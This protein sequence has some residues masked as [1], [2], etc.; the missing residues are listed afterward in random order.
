MRE[1]IVLVL[2]FCSFSLSWAQFL[3]TAS[4]TTKRGNAPSTMGKLNEEKKDSK[5]NIVNYV[6]ILSNDTSTLNRDKRDLKYTID[7][8]SL[9]HIID[10]LRLV[11][12]E[13]EASDSG[14]GDQGESGNES[15]MRSVLDLGGY[16]STSFNNFS[17]APKIF[18]KSDFELFDWANVRGRIYGVEA[19]QDSGKQDIGSQIFIP[20]ASTFG[21]NF[22]TSLSLNTIV[23]LSNTPNNDTPT[24][25]FVFDFFYSA[26]DLTSTDT[27]IVELSTGIVQ[28]KY[29]INLMFLP[30]TFS[31]YANYNIAS[32]VTRVDDYKKAFGEEISTKSY[33]FDVGIAASF[34]KFILDVDFIILSKNLKLLTN[35]PNDIV[36]PIIRVGFEQPLVFVGN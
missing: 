8:L 16:L 30:N 18:A 6:G 17:V 7:S 12:C 24:V 4:K 1:F 13:S 33:F 3:P 11:Q 20:E 19:N 34:G 14:N 23:G 31:V 25:Y 15:E 26:K 29:G 21:I 10:S 36:K 35:S 28:T 5:T 22:Q 32:A 2:T 27:S 9:V